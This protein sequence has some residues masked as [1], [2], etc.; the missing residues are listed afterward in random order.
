MNRLKFLKVQG[1]ETFIYQVLN[2]K[3][4]CRTLTESIS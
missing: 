1:M 2:L 3:N 4:T